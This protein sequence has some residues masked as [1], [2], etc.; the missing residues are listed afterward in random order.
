MKDW[1]LLQETVQVAHLNSETTNM[2]NSNPVAFISQKA[3]CDSAVWSYT[4]S[5][6]L[7]ALTSWTSRWFIDLNT[8]PKQP[9]QLFHHPVIMASDKQASET[10]KSPLRVI[11]HNSNDKDISFHILR[12]SQVIISMIACSANCPVCHTG[13]FFPHDTFF[14][15][16]TLSQI[17]TEHVR[18]CKSLC[19]V[20][21]STPTK[22]TDI[23]IVMF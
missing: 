2:Q 18:E 7:S 9:A 19:L 10:W 6:L 13:L 4:L 3:S 12:R 14:F 16:I 21:Q 5:R 15:I 1:P 11:F 8:A 20:Y 23:V 22:D 17:S